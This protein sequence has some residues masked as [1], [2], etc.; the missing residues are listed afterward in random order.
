MSILSQIVRAIWTD[1]YPK[2]EATVEAVEAKV[3]AVAETAVERVEQKVETVAAAVEAVAPAP[4]PG[5]MLEEILAASAAQHKAAT[6]ETLDWEHSIVDL[7]KL[8]GVD[9]SLANRKQLA[10]EFGYRGAFAGS[11]ADNTWLRDQFLAWLRR[12]S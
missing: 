10:A 4:P 11:A 1:L 12:Q 5:R 3:E 7:M 6:G 9:S 2:V 8:A